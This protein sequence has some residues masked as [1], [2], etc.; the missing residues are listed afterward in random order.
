MKVSVSFKVRNGGVI[1]KDH[2]YCLF[3]AISH[4]VKYLH[5]DEN[6]VAHVLRIQGQRIFENYLKLSEESRVTLR[7]PLED[8]H[9]L[10]P[11]EGSTLELDGLPLTLGSTII[12]PLQPYEELYSSLAIVKFRAVPKDANGKMD[13]GIAKDEFVNYVFSK[14]SRSGIKAKVEFGP[15]PRMVAIK[16][17]ATL[18]WSLHI[19]P[20]TP[21]GSI[22]LQ[23]E[24]LGAKRH[25]GCGIFIGSHAP[26]Q[27]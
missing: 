8:V 13:L 21:E 22:K 14:L 3:S 16:G 6:V 23:E 1:P 5:D 26:R 7:M 12:E 10:A 27:I 25:M 18:G 20:E 9:Q 24:G 17:T 2:G 11:L 19:R 15:N 4:L